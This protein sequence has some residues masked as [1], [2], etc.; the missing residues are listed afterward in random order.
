MIDGQAHIAMRSRAAQLFEAAVLAG[1]C[2]LAF[3]WLIPAQ[4]SEG[5]IGL[6]P[7]FLPRLCAAAAGLLIAVDGVLRFLRQAPDARYA[8]GWAAFLRLGT[9]ACLGTLALYFGGIVPAVVVCC[10]ATAL[11]LGERR[12]PHVLLPALCCAAAFWLVFR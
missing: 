12:L 11:A 2:L 4:T 8:E 6:S 5:G 7:A 10:V 1:A 9:A 3:K